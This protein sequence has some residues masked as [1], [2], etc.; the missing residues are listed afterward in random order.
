[1]ASSAHE[2]GPHGGAFAP[3]AACLTLAHCLAGGTLYELVRHFGGG[4]AD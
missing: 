3:E 4:A 1:M 2:D